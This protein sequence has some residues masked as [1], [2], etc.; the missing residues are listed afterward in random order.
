LLLIQ[1]II[2]ASSPLALLFHILLMGKLLFMT[3]HKSLGIVV[4][5]N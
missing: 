2:V 5:M 1:L 4:G 3:A